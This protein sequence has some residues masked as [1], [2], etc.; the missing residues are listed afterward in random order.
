MSFSARQDSIRYMRNGQTVFLA[1]HEAIAHYFEASRTP[2]QLDQCIATISM[3]D[4]FH[5]STLMLISVDSRSVQ[6]SRGIT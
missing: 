5:C 3:L 1:G 4:T 6:A 2:H